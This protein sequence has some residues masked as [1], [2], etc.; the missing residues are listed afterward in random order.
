M[1]FSEKAAEKLVDKMVSLAKLIA[2]N[3]IAIEKHGNPITVY[4]LKNQ[5]EIKREMM[6]ILTSYDVFE[7]EDEY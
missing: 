4:N 1:H 5:D 7:M 2:Q 6:A 3:E